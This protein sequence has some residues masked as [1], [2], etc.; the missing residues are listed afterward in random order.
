MRYVDSF[1]YLIISIQET[2]EKFEEWY[3][4][5]KRYIEWTY[6]LSLVLAFICIFCKQVV[7]GVIIFILGMVI[8]GIDRIVGWKYSVRRWLK[9]CVFYNLLFSTTLACIIQG[10]IKYAI[11]TPLFI[12][13]YLIIWLFLSLISNSKVALLVNEIISGITATIFTIGT[14]LINIALKNMPS[15]NDYLRYFNT[16]EAFEIALENKETQAWEFVGTMVLEELEVVFLSFLPVIGVT[17]LCI[18]MVKIKVYWM[19]K[20]EV[21][22]PEQ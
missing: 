12:G 1:F 16:E 14:F 7:L 8:I 15:S 17:A 18:I 11:M 22:E 19:E 9:I 5:K 4:A 20:N 21:I 3:V 2:L 10:A 6:I 13:L